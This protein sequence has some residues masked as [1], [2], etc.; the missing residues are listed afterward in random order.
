M[1]LSLEALRLGGI[2][3]SQ[4]AA[5]FQACAAPASFTFLPLTHPSPRQPHKMVVP[6]SARTAVVSSQ[7]FGLHYLKVID[8]EPIL[9]FL[10][11]PMLQS[12]FH[13]Q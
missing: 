12:L 11:P 13:P 3:V 9:L 2:A 10:S 7:I 6:V 4:S 1:Y 5:T 8:N